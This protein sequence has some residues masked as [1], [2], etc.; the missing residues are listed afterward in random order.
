MNRVEKKQVVESTRSMFESASSAVVVHY[1]G[2]SVADMTSLRTKAREHGVRVKVT[3]N[4]LTSIAANDTDYNVIAPLMK[5]PTAVMFG[6]DE[7]SPAKVAKDFSKG[8][9]NFKIV[10]GA[11][12]GNL[13]DEEGVI[14][15]ASMPSLDESRAKI[16]GLLNAPA[17][18]LVGVLQAP[19]GKLARVFG[20]Y[21]KAE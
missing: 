17:G 18:K 20:A 2:M 5:G 1:R 13:L 10:G 9:E 15:L 7:V 3:K 4:T 16:V 14:T 21:S 11:F 12:G 8:N 19:A 6:D